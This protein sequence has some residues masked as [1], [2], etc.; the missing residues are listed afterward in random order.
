V[1]GKV[2][3]KVVRGPLKGRSFLFERHDH[4]IVGRSKSCHLHLPD[5]GFMSRHHFLLEV[6]PPEVRLRDLGSMNGTFVNGNKCGGR[7]Q[8]DSPALGTQYSFPHLNLKNGDRISVGETEILVVVETPRIPPAAI[9]CTVCGR[10]TMELK[11]SEEA[12]YYICRWCWEK[13][14][15]DPVPVFGAGVQIAGGPAGKPRTRNL[16]S[17]QI[18][19]P[20]GE[21]SQTAVHLA[22]DKNSGEQ[23]AFKVLASKAIV[24]DE[25]RD[26]FLRELS[27]LQD[28]AHPN[29][30]AYKGAGSKGG[31]FFIVQ[32][33]CNRGSAL[34]F[35]REHG[36]KLSIEVAGPLMLDALRGLVYLHSNGCI[37]R[38]IKPQNIML[39]DS[40]GRLA[41][42]L[43]D[44]AMASSLEAAGLGGLSTTSAKG[45]SFLPYMPREQ[46]TDH[47]N[48]N[49]LS[50][51]W[52]LAASFYHMTTGVPPR[53]RGEGR[54]PL[55]VIL[56]AE[57]V[58]IEKHVAIAPHALAAALNRA[59][60]VSLEARFQ[61][62]KAF[63]SA[64]ESALPTCA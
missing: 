32:E 31:V 37:H 13:V 7:G 36:G 52:S 43:G 6:D 42:K 47:R 39:D 55:E 57:T 25:A 29:V 46:L 9:R 58:P 62:A 40:G 21:G 23:V 48:R 33:Y 35:L 2:T 30:V 19:R 54:D 34:Q 12:G 4:F 49:P 41:A 8:F 1:S 5:D 18:V 60:A 22:V 53:T 20:I 26:S 16:S 28:L 17:Y 51:I 11:F 24:D 14:I 63:L 10:V 64:M 15:K 44:A 27:K 59:L 45:G 50:D 3:L 38:D 61:S 56:D